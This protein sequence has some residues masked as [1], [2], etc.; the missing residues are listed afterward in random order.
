MGQPDIIPKTVGY[1]GHRD[2]LKLSRFRCIFLVIM[3]QAYTTHWLVLRP[4]ETCGLGWCGGSSQIISGM[5]H[6]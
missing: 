6:L 5:T 3:F 2:K 1:L 4:S